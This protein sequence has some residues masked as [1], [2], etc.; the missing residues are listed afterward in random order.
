MT[1]KGK[2]HCG[3]TAFELSKVP[4]SVT[5]CTC[6]FCAKR[7]VLWANYSPEEVTFT[8]KSEL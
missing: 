1:I 3:A 2:C 5:R 4:K 6:T 8:S 7:G